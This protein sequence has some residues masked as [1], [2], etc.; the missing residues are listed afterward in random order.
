MDLAEW[1]KFFGR[2]WPGGPV[3]PKRAPAEALDVL[4]AEDDVV[5]RENLRTLLED[6]GYT[7][8]AAGDGEEAIQIAW[9][10]PPRVV[11]L[12]LSMPRLD[13]LGL[14]RRLR[15]NPHTRHAHIHCLSGHV[16]AALQRQARGAGCEAFL[17]K[18][19]DAEALLNLV[20]AQVNPSERVVSGLTK[21]EAE[22]VLDWLEA[23]G[24]TGARVRFQTGKG[25]SVTYPDG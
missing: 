9:R 22:D 5:V 4:I 14:A 10:S 8:R 11:F 3:H 23:H 16:D 13:G 24:K 12:D 1:R 17:T 19:L 21:A 2:L 20:R 25:Y 15:A 18:P 6:Q 7:C